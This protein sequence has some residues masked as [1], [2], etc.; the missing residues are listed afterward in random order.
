M[1]GFLGELFKQLIE[2]K[3]IYGITTVQPKRAIKKCRVRNLRIE[4]FLGKVAV[5]LPVPKV[6]RN[7]SKQGSCADDFVEQI[8]KKYKIGQESSEEEFT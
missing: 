6:C 8:V 5:V 1:G 4:Y 3:A 7:C 2:A